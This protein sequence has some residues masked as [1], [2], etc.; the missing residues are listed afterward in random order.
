[1]EEQKT[2]WQLVRYAIVS[3]LIGL[4]QYGSCTL[5]YLA[6]KNTFWSFFISNF[7]GNTVGFIFN[8]LFVFKVHKDFLSYMIYMLVV[9]SLIIFVSF[10]GDYSSNEI[11]EKYNYNPAVVVTAINVV[12]G[13]LLGTALF[14]LQKHVLMREE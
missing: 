9:M 7:I 11:I 8:M 12:Y 4:V 13:F 6:T 2:F 14:P 10:L 1:M 5:I 3:T